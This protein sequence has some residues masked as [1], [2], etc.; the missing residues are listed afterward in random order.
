MD[1]PR[2]RREGTDDEWDSCVR[3][4]YNAIVKDQNKYILL[5][6]PEEMPL[7]SAIRRVPELATQVS[8]EG[9][10]DVDIPVKARNP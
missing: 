7:A 5:D 3:I 4:W 9:G 8:A 1:P 10:K 2:C 6:I